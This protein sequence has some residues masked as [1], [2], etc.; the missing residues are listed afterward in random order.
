MS[1]RHCSG[2]FQEGQTGLGPV[3]RRV[4]ETS[5]RCR[6]RRHHD[7]KHE[8][9]EQGPIRSAIGSLGP[10]SPLEKLGRDQEGD[11]RGPWTQREDGSTF[12]AVCPVLPQVQGCRPGGRSMELLSRPFVGQEVQDCGQGSI[13]TCSK[14]CLEDGSGM[15]EAVIFHSSLS[16]VA[17]ALEKDRSCPIMS[18][19]SLVQTITL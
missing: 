15:A 2:G 10:R 19:V 5:S 18:L 4:Q 1:R 16:R 9:H 8:E 3:G 17:C 6:C 7:Y 14:V 11:P 12:G 13:Q